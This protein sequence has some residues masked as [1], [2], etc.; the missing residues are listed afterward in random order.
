MKFVQILLLFNYSL[1]VL[2]TTTFLYE[3]DPPPPR[4]IY[5]EVG[6]KGMPV[7]KSPIRKCQ[8]NTAQL[9]RRVIFLN[10]FLFCTNLNQS[11]IYAIFVMRKSLYLQSANHRKIGFAIRKSAN[12]HMRICD[13]PGRN[14]GGKSLLQKQVGS[15]ICNYICW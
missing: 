3:L 15:S 8:H 7:R 2:K 9:R 10:D 13:L 14:V 1:D 11:I 6:K 4:H 5:S 12:C